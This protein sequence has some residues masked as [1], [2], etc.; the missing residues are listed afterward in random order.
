LEYNFLEVKF[1]GGFMKKIAILLI[2]LA[3][4]F[5]FSILSFAATTGGS[6]NLTTEET[7]AGDT[8]LTEE[9]IPAGGAD[10]A[11]GVDNAAGGTASVTEEETPKALPKTGGIP[12][13]AFYAIGGIMV[14][15]ALIL[16]MRKT[17]AASKN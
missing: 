2:A 10:N 9:N 4:I 15:A 8:Y 5:S 17:K 1:G 7:P 6:I 14:L 16:S 11:A 3:I 13:E 12:A